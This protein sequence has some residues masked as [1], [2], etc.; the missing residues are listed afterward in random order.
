MLAGERDQLIRGDL[1]ALLELDGGMDALARELAHVSW[2]RLERKGR[3][4]ALRAAWAA[5]DAQVVCYMDVDLSTDL[6]ALLPLVGLA[7]FAAVIASQALISGAFSITRQAIQLGLAP[8]LEVEQTS[9]RERGQIYV[10]QVNWFLAVA[11]I[12]IVIGFETSGALAAAY[13]IAVTMTMVITALLLHVVATER[14][15]WP[16]WATLAAIVLVLAYRIEEGAPGGAGGL[17]PLRLGL[18]AVATLAAATLIL[19]LPDPALPVLAGAHVERA[20]R[21]SAGDEV[22]LLIPVAGGA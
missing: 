2:I 16:R 13:G 22:A 19:A 11:T 1:G 9:E 18:G 17:P 4:R 3:G 6:R 21:L 7:T 12:L 10:P 14:C 5:S 20:Q 15:G 8:R